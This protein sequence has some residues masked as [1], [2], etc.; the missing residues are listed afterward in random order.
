MLD[1][2]QNGFPDNHNLNT[3]LYFVDKQRGGWVDGEMTDRNGIGDKVDAF[4]RNDFKSSAW[5]A[6]KKKFLIRAMQLELR[7]FK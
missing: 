1:S 6:R 3:L 5:M 4:W 7:T 2:A